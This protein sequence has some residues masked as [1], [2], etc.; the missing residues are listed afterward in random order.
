PGSGGGVAF[1]DGTSI[2]EDVL[3]CDAVTR[4]ARRIFDRGEV[5]MFEDADV[6]VGHVVSDYANLDRNDEKLGL[7]PREPAG[8]DDVKSLLQQELALTCVDGAGPSLHL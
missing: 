3:E 1:E 4:G 8:V 5:D 6:G 7:R 2:F